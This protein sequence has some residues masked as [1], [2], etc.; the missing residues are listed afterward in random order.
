MRYQERYGSCGAGMI[1]NICR[2]YGQIVSEARVRALARTDVNGTDEPGVMAALRAL[3]YT[4]TQFT[5]ESSAKAWLLLHGAVRRGKAVG[6]AVDDDKHWVACVASLGE[7]IAVVDSA[8][9]RANKFEN[10]IHFLDRRQLMER[11][12]RQ[13]GYYGIVAGKGK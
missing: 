4:A 9:E 10:G 12:V 11:W 6:I 2:A 1:V 13:D 5:E 3:G 8:W 7:R